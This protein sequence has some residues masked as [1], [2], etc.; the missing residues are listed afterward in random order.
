MTCRAVLLFF[1]AVALAWGWNAAAAD[2]TAER[3]EKGV[4]IKVDGQPFAEYLTNSGTKP[5]VWPVIGPTGKAM[6]RAY[7]MDPNA[8]GSKDH[9]H[10][11][12]I[13]FTHGNV[14]GIDFWDE[15]GDAAKRGFTRHREFVKVE[16]GPQ[17]IV[18][19]R[20]DWVAPGDKKILEDERRLTFAA[21]GDVRWID[22]DITLKASQGPVT[23]G[24]TKEGTMG[25]RV[26]DT[27]K[28]DAKRGGKIVT[29]EG[30]VDGAAWGKPAAWVDYYGP[31]DGEQVGMAIFNHPTSFHFPTP[32]HVRTYGL[33]AA[34]PFSLQDFT[35]GKQNGFFTLPAGK[36]ITLN[37][38]I[39]LHKGDE[40]VG[41]VAE[42]YAAYAKQAK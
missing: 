17:A 40:K 12:S 19:T 32:W 14:N 39:Y 18:V 42:A 24:D 28:V 15:G 8:K 31:V 4:L 5:I 16:S 3:S 9:R 20:N 23:F 2:V 1:G 6:T 38:R 27:M 34:N 30:L 10:H 22:F 11:R 21:S 35:N 36:T 41:K 37:Y 25:T 29:S 13:W 26:P 33:F 7:P